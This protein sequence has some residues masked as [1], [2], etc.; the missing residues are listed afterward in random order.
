VINNKQGENSVNCKQGDPDMERNFF[1]NKLSFAVFLV[2]AAILYTTVFTTTSK[3]FKNFDTNTTTTTFKFMSLL[4]VYRDVKE[5]ALTA[6]TP[7]QAKKVAVPAN[8]LQCMAENIYYEANS[9][10]YA[11]KIAVGQV[12][13]NRVNSPNYPRTVCGVIYEGS[14]NTQT[15]QCQFSWSCAP[16]EP[17]NKNSEGWRESLKAASELLSNKDHM[18]DITEGATNYHADYVSPPWAKKLKFVVKIDQHLFYS[19]S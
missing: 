13:L 15:T 12:V 3:A 19:R 10:S 5:Q 2:L 9:Q 8:D 6:F 11:G 17:I 4:D 18:I 14:Q 1:L 16:H 7:A